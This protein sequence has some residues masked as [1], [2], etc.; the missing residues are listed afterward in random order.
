MFLFRGNLGLTLC[1]TQNMLF[2]ILSYIIF[3][4][5]KIIG[6]IPIY[7]IKCIIYRVFL[8]IFLKQ[9]S[10]TSELMKFEHARLVNERL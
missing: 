9:T 2:N 5:Y 4:I 6:Q 3:Q 7:S 10:N 8:S 1:F